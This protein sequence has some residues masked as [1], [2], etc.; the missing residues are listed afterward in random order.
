MAMEEVA[1][2]TSRFLTTLVNIVWFGTMLAGGWMFM[3][4]RTACVPGHAT[5]A[6]RPQFK[7]GLGI[8]TFDDCDQGQ[9]V[10]YAYIR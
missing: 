2:Y 3:S 8:V 5:H 9:V 4:S 6:S 7:C 10:N 1:V